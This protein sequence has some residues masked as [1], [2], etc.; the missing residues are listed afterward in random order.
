LPWKSSDNSFERI[1]QSENYV[2]S[3]LDLSVS[4]TIKAME[5]LEKYYGMDITKRN[6]KTIERI[7]LEL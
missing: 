1:G 6:W 7:A 4:K 2:L 5:G 3:V